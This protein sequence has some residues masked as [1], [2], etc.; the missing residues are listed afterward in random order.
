MSDT[1]RSI[2]SFG[3]FAMSSIGTFIVTVALCYP[4]SCSGVFPSMRC[5]TV[6]GTIPMSQADAGAAATVLGVVVGCICALIA[7][8]MNDRSQSA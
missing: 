3:A 4:A 5:Q 1:A 7:S 6:L 2:N 8:S